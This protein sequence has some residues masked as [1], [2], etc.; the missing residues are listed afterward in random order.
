M[1][2]MSCYC[3]TDL[4]IELFPSPVLALKQ[5]GLL[6]LLNEGIFCF[7]VPF[8]LVQAPRHVPVLRFALIKIKCFCK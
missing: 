5:D 4:D 2:G 1:Q 8:Q 3:Y 6:L 7:P